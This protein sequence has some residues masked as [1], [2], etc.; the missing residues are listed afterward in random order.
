[1]KNIT[2][3]LLLTLTLLLSLTL[4]ACSSKTTKAPGTTKAPETTKALEKKIKIGILQVATHSALDSAKEG[5]IK[6]L[7]DAGFD[8]TKVEINFQNPEGDDAQALTMAES[9]IRKSDLALAIATPVA[10]ALM[11]AAKNQGSNIP[12]LFTA[13]TDPLDAKLVASIENPGGNITG[14]SDMNPVAEQIQ[15]I[16]QILPNAKKLGIIYK[17]SEINSEVQAN[18]AKAEASKQGLT[19]EIKTCID[20]SDLTIVLQQLINTGVDCIFLPT[21]NLIASNMEAIRKITV[22]DNK[23]P[24]ICGEAGLVDNGGFVSLSIDYFELG[25]QTGQM[26][27]EILNGKAPKDIAVGSQ[28]LDKCQFVF[29]EEVAKALGITIPEDLIK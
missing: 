11:N 16:K 2:K 19:T 18:M 9:I 28:G 27:V 5:F 24:T 6:A 14:T 23:I 10:T 7:K 17:A 15:L 12:I 25:Y 22:E 26:A 4:I 20:Q 1:M 21:D 8:E 29:N 3:L 13:V